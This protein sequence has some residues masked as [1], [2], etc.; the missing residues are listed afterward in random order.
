MF[1][2]FFLNNHFRSQPLHIAASASSFGTIASNLT[3]TD[4]ESSVFSDSMA[5]FF[6]TSS[7]RKNGKGGNNQNFDTVIKLLLKQYPQ[8]AQTPH[9]KSGRL[10]LVLAARVGH[11]TWNDGMKALLRAYPPAL[12]S[13]SKGMIPVKLY[14]HALALIGG[15]RPL[16]SSEMDISLMTSG[17]NHSGGNS[18][19]SGSGHSF[20]NSRHK[21]R[22]GNRLL[23]NLLL[24]KQRQMREL[25]GTG[26][27]TVTTSASTY[28]SGRVRN[29]LHDSNHRSRA[30][31]SATSSFKKK[32]AA[33]IE[34]K[35]KKGKVDPKLATTMFE[36]LR[37][38]PDLV[39]VGRS[40]QAEIERNRLEANKKK[41]FSRAGVSPGGATVGS[42]LAR[43]KKTMSPKLLER[44]TVFQRKA[45]K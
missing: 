30:R 15:A 32:P 38:K 16:P 26:S 4:E 14:P 21:G 37:M 27:S 40:Y 17:S 31:I 42:G 1:L 12:F 39:E 24:S 45:W 23:H 34:T 2:L 6:S 35:E 33:T 10:P 36:L 7:N 18:L 41:D 5:S 25:M 13:G 22:G 9:G 11:R 8:A 19:P 44:M 28:R 20:G 29:H 43:R 3:M